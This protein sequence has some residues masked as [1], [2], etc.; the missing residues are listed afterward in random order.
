MLAIVPV[1][2]PRRGKQRLASFFDA[3]ARAE[4]VSAMLLDV[5]DACEAARSVDRTLLVTPSPEIA[6]EGCT[7]MIDPGQG[8]A[9]AIDAAL[10]RDEAKSGALVLMADCPLVTGAALDVLVAS[11]A[12]LSLA[13][14]Q[15]GGTNALAMRPGT[16]IRPAFGVPGSCAVTMA[17]ARELGIRPKLVHDPVFAFDLDDTDDVARVL[18][19]GAGTRTAALLSGLEPA[20]ATLV[21]QPA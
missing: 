21:D 4:L 9:H 12:P 6:P 1:N 14:A 7:V 18:S 20:V 16:L 11:A 17:T 8:H 5:L 10:Q 13:P 3:D 2:N 15:D 19:R